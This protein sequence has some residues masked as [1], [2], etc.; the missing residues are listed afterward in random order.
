MN[1]TWPRFDEPIAIDERHSWTALFDSYDQRNENAYYIVTLLEPGRTAGRF[2][3]RID[4]GWSGDD[5]TTAEFVSGVRSRVDWVARQGKTN[6][7]YT[8]RL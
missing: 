3:A 5:W 7:G 4:M 6:T 8:G 1:F 2:M